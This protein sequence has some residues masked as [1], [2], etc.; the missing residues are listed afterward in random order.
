MNFIS[1]FFK[2]EPINLLCHLDTNFSSENC[3]FDFTYVSVVL[4]R[5]CWLDGSNKC[6]KNGAAEVCTCSH[7]LCNTGV[8]RHR[9][10][11]PSVISLLSLL[12]SLLVTRHLAT[13]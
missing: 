7:D 1:Q 12:T 9:T 3:V 11:A 2:T 5:G 10:L 4:L 13:S 6:L 8:S